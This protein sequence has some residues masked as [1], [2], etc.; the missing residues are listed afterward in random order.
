MAGNVTVTNSTLSD[1]CNFPSIQFGR[2]YTSRIGQDTVVYDAEGADVTHTDPIRYS[3]TSTSE[4]ATINNDFVLGLP[5][6][7]SISGATITADAG[8]DKINVNVDYSAS[9]ATI[10]STFGG[11]ASDSNV[12]RTAS[13][14]TVVGKSC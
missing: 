14:A 6:V 8:S 7:S 13:G 12:T 3:K 2:Y 11:I 9:G 5:S 10:T 4:G 1:T